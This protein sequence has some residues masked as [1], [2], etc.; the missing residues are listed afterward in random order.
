MDTTLHRI[1]DHNSFINGTKQNKGAHFGFVSRTV[2]KQGSSI[3]VRYALCL[4]LE[5]VKSRVK[6]SLSVNS[7]ESLLY[8]GSK[9]IIADMHKQYMCIST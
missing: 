9:F 8:P 4:Q 1:K 2:V 3:K 6:S 5:L 7:T